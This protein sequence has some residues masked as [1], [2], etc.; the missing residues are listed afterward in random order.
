MSETL[1]PPP[2]TSE[3]VPDGNP[4]GR[5]VSPWLLG[6]GV[7]AM[8]FFSLGVL[9]AVVAGV[10]MFALR[11]KDRPVQ[12]RRASSVAQQRLADGSILVLEQVT[13]GREH[14]FHDGV[15]G[16]PAQGLVEP[17]SPSEGRTIRTSEDMIVVWF[18]QWDPTTGK[19][20]D[21]DWFLR[22]VALDSHGCEIENRDKGRYAQQRNGSSGEHGGRGPF[23]R[24]T[25]GPYDMILT[26][27]GLPVFRSDGESFT[28][29]LYDKQN[30]R[31]A[32]FDVPDPR[33]VGLTYDEWKPQPLPVTESDGD[34]SLSLISLTAR[35]SESKQ[36]FDGVSLTEN[37]VRLTPLFQTKQAG[38]PTDDWNSRSL[39]VFDALGNQASVWD[40]NL[41]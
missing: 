24:L 34:V 26:H 41:C 33:P 6:C 25:G 4:H 2:E 40:C 5:N 37:R 7:L 13:F 30:R 17:V 20:R 23:S 9:A 28:L 36:T 3:F 32:D 39:R 29:R 19:P 15:R 21:F 35:V 31:V 16:A 22:C 8:A 18:T 12:I 10:L 27:F 11:A 14:H 1:G 38:E